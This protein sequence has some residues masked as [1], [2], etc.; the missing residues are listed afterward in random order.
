MEVG[1]VVAVGDGA[2]VHTGIE[3]AV[4]VGDR[5][6]EVDVDSAG[7]GVNVGVGNRG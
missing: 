3:V 6:G 1:S 5:G 7:A 2:T 4:A